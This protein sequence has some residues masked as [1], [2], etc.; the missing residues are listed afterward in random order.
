MRKTGFICDESYFWHDAGSG[1]LY[2]PPGGFLQVEGSAESPENKRRFK[3]LME[4]SGLYDMLMLIKPFPATEEQLMYFHT[5]D[6]IQRVKEASEKGNVLVGS[7][8]MVGKGS[9]EIA[10]LAAGGTI[11]AVDAVVKGKCD[12]AYALTRPPGHHAQANQGNG[13]CIFNNA[14][15]AAHYAQKELGL[16]KVMILDWDAHHGNGTE[17]AFY[18]DPNV[19][20]VSIHQNELH[21]SSRGYI[22]HIGEGEGKG[23][24]INIPLHPGTGDMGYLYAFEQIIIPVTNR[25][26]PELI[27]VCAGQDANMFDPLARMMLSVD[28]YTKMTKIVRELAEVHCGGKLVMTH[29]GGYSNAYVPFCSHAIVEELLGVSMGISDPFITAFDGASYK[30]LADHHKAKIDEARDLHVS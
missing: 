16:N 4:R 24:N 28:G 20:F 8:A 10:V 25:Y 13:Y 3:N 2:L 7:F 1:V 26:K 19:L 29:E 5:K 15:I 23:Y 6:Y 14:V 22:D 21:P 9:Y 30:I 27:I 11:T 12:N 17:D 18:S